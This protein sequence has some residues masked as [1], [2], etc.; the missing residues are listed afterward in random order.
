MLSPAARRLRPQIRHCDHPIRLT[1]HTEVIHLD[2]S[3]P[4]PST[5]ASGTAGRQPM[6]HRASSCL[7]LFGSNSSGDGRNTS[8]I[9]GYE[10]AIEAIKARTSR[11]NERTKTM[12]LQFVIA[13]VIGLT[14]IANAQTP[15]TRELNL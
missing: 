9:I 3:L 10:T 7:F 8:L 14:G 1:A 12:N 13:A 11:T 15:A 6:T 5:C 4:K 2:V